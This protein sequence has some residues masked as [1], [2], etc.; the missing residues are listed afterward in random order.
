MRK[1]YLV[2]ILCLFVSCSNKTNLQ[3]KAL[4]YPN[5]YINPPQN[6]NSSLY[7]ELLKKQN[8]DTLFL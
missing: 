2:F 3:T 1:I 6:T 8:I 4:E 5:W 7:F